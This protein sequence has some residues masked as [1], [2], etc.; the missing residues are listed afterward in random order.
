MNGYASPMVFTC[1]RW[2][3]VIII[4]LPLVI[5]KLIANKK[6]IKKHLLALSILG[7]TGIALNTTLIYMGLI[8]TTAM[9]AA[10][11]SVTSPIFIVLAA[12]L[13]LREPISVRKLVGLIISVLGVIFIIS[14]GHWFNLH[15]LKFNIGDLII[16]LA[17]LMW[18]IYSTVVKLIADKIDPLLLLFIT[19]V[20]AEIFLI[21]AAMIEYS[22]KHMLTINSTI[23]LGLIYTAVFPAIIGYVSWSIGLREL[24]NSTCGIL[25][26]LSVFF[27]SILAVIFLKEHLH[28]FHA[29]GF[30]LVLTGS[31]LT[32]K[33]IFHK[34]N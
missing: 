26:N 31:Y 6:V 34:K 1:L 23:I 19:A 18:V 29:I 14:Q 15:N 20:F 12:F 28:F 24:G 21:P 11:I 32:L 3:I 22:Y 2:L 17:I 16:L 10:L 30:A 13:F 25:Y 9:N 4:L 27:S 8:Y 7:L 33:K 5:K